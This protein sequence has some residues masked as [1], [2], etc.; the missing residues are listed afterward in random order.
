MLLSKRPWIALG[1]ET[2]KRAQVASPTAPIFLLSVPLTH[3]AQKRS[4]AESLIGDF[5][6]R[7]LDTNPSL[8]ITRSPKRCSIGLNGNK[9][10]PFAL[11]GANL[12]LPFR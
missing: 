3:V 11:I 5:P 12:C 4:D 1:A 7:R 8:K 6:G 2:Q 9:G 10:T